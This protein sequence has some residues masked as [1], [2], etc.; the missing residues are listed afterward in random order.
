MA[1][2][3]AGFGHPA[4][5]AL[6]AMG[7]VVRPAPV[8]VFVAIAADH[9]TLRR[10][11]TRSYWCDGWAGPL[12]RLPGAQGGERMSFGRVYSPAVLVPLALI[13]GEPQ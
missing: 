13:C 7:V 1:I 12:L 11:F 2:R 3:T 9:P 10:L 8:S 6:R 5:R 4:Q